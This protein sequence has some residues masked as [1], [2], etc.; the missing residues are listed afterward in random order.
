VRKGGDRDKFYLIQNRTKNR[1]FGSGAKRAKSMQQ[2]TNTLRVVK[3]YKKSVLR[4]RIRDPV[5]FLT[6][7]SGILDG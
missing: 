3:A 2:E 6:P 1:E 7:G 5:I 4:I